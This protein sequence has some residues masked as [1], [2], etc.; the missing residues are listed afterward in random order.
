MP[1]KLLIVFRDR[2]V[3]GRI[4]WSRLAAS[5][6]GIL[7]DPCLPLGPKLVSGTLKPVLSRDLVATRVPVIIGK[8]VFLPN[9]LLPARKWE[10]PESIIQGV[11]QALPKNMHF[12]GPTVRRPAGKR[13]I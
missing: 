7:L 4:P 5:L 10:H 3:S 6:E 11:E 12:P 9:E 8:I 13:I 1:E 2:R